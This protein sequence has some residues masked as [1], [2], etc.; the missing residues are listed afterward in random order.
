LMR[1]TRL[2]SVVRKG[3]MLSLALLLSFGSIGFKASNASAA[4][5]E[6]WSILPTLTPKIPSSSYLGKLDVD[7]QGTV[8][9]TDIGGSRILYLPKNSATWSVKPIT[10]NTGYSE[11]GITIDNSGKIY[12]L[13]TS[14]GRIQM[15]NSITDD[16]TF[17]AGSSEWPLYRP[18]GIAVDLNGNLYVTE[19]NINRVLK[20]TKDLTDETGTTGTWSL[21]GDGYSSFTYPNGIAV[22]HDGNVYVSIGNGHRIMKWTR[23]PLDGSGTWSAWAGNAIGVT[24]AGTGLG[25]FTSPSDVEVDPSGNVYVV[26]KVNNRIQMWT[27]ETNSWSMWGKADYTSGSAAGEFNRPTGIAI[28]SQGDLYVADGDKYSVQK[29]ER[30]GF[31]DRTDVAFDKNVMDT[32][33]GHYQDIIVKLTANGKTLTDILLDG[34]SIGQNYTQSGNDITI[35]KGILESAELGERVLSFIMS[36]GTNPVLRVT[37]SDSTPPVP[38]TP[39][40][41][42]AVPGNGVVNLS[43][44]QVAGATGYKIYQSLT[45]SSNGTEIAVTEAVY[46]DHTITNLV[47]G[48]NY[49]FSVKATN[50]GSDSPYSNM[51]AATPRTVADTPSNVVATAGNREASVSFDTPYNGGSAITGYT[52]TAEPGGAQGT[53]SG[54]TIIVTGLTNGTAYTFKVVAHNVAGDSISSSPSTSVIPGEAPGSPTNVTATAGDAAATIK[55]TAPVSTGSQPI[56][57]FEVLSPTGTVLATGA[58]SPITVTGLTNGTA[59]TFQVRAVSAAGEGTLSVESNSVTPAVPSSSGGGGGGGTPSPVTSKTGELTLPMGTSGEVSLDEAIFITI[60]S[61]ATSTQLN[62]T[63]EQLTNSQGLLGNK[64]IPASAIYEILK[65]FTE[66]FNHPVTLSFEFDFAKL[67]SG[68]TVAIFYYDEVAKAWVK[69]EGGKIDGTR[70]SVEVDHFTK[71]AALVV[72]KATGLPVTG[73]VTETETTPD[74]SFSDISSHW[75]EGNIKQAVNEGIVKGYVDGTFKPN[76]T[77]TRAEFA[78]MLMNA[79]KPADEGAELTFADTSKIG[80]WAQKAVAQAVQASMINGYED[81]T[82]R[83]S[84]QL[85]RAELAAIIANALKLSSETGAVTEFADDQSIP[86]WA[87]GAVGALKKLDLVTGKGANNFDPKATTTRAEAVTVLLKMLAQESK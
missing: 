31:L 29:L 40:L 27:K 15:A 47:N 83:P 78:V 70:I 87:K 14:N 4:A 28:D 3:M 30:S 17:I 45:N 26:D 13:D 46:Q 25:A 8:Y 82:F 57:R 51:L 36:G 10:T 34:V 60:P 75:A 61:N 67:T 71:F 79:L 76:A 22:E 86:A 50:N 7:S 39:V 33:A 49:Y 16:W 6:T 44:Q 48:T 55:F 84:G 20:W 69:V 9:V 77:V 81:G 54:N 80:A 68:Q 23:D 38:G 74:V 66:N 62:L 52:V 65:N 63:I 59:Y 43:W 21:L 19:A 11:N 32:S 53:G 5:G 35:S 56:S 12:V 64:E 85:T 37:V 41:G 2:M 42:G 72:D 24:T 18:S 58:T 1:S 73:K